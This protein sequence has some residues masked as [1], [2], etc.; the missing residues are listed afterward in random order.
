MTDK[1]RTDL[2]LQTQKIKKYP[3]MGM[4]RKLRYILSL[5]YIRIGILFILFYWIYSHYYTGF[6]STFTKQSEKF[7]HNK[8]YEE[9]VEEIKSADTKK[10]YISDS[11]GGVE[12]YLYQEMFEKEEYQGEEI[13]KMNNKD[14]NSYS[15]IFLIITL[16]NAQHNTGLQE[17]FRVTVSSMLKY[18]SVP[19]AIHII[20]DKESQKVAAGIVKESYI[21][22]RPSYRVCLAFIVCNVYSRRNYIKPELA[23]HNFHLPFCQEPRNLTTTC[24]LVPVLM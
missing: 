16:T 3:Q 8:Q 6:G 4:I 17:K 11:R 21:E 12:D 9:K 19:V 24:R 13:L 5:K 22:G 7:Y 15:E 20:G 18:N 14:E 10:S 23:C 2:E 1:L